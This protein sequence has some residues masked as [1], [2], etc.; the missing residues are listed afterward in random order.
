MQFHRLFESSIDS[1]LSLYFVQK[2][3]RVIRVSFLLLPSQFTLEDWHI[4]QPGGC[5][6]GPRAA[7][8]EF[9]KIHRLGQTFHCAEQIYSLVYVHRSEIPA[10]FLFWLFVTRLKRARRPGPNENV[11][12]IMFSCAR[13][14]ENS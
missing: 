1:F 12:F 10:D 7:A 11:L 3:C 5:C 6:I 2:R 13:L 9:N 14:L 8:I 4:K